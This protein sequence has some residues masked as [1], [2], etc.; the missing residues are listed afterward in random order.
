MKEHKCTYCITNTLRCTYDEASQVSSS[1]SAMISIDF[2]PETGT[3]LA[4]L[5]PVLSQLCF[6]SGI[7]SR[8]DGRFASEGLCF[9]FSQFHVF[10][11]ACF[12]LC[13]DGDFSHELGGSVNK[14]A[15]NLLRGGAKPL[16]MVASSSSSMS[17]PPSM[18]SKESAAGTLDGGVESS[19]EEGSG[20]WLAGRLKWLQVNPAAPRFVG[21]ASSIRLVKNALEIRKECMP[22]GDDDTSSTIRDAFGRRP[23]YWS[24]QPVRPVKVHRYTCWCAHAATSGRKASSRATR[25]RHGASDSHSR[26]TTCWQAWWT[27]S[28]RT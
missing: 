6:L 12:Q 4:R 24:V 16:S 27:G 26:L 22:T 9:F 14:D 11:P 13:P 18:L 3:T 2:V 28:L 5:S 1:L 8:E 7:P 19:D 10:K 23:E 15:W 21:K 25:S 20:A 17:P